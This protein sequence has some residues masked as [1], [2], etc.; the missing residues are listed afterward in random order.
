MK[1]KTKSV[2]KD[3]FGKL[4]IFIFCVVFIQL[5]NYFFG[6]DNSIIGVIILTGLFMFMRGN[7]GIDVRQASVSIFLMFIIVAFAPKLSLYNPFVGIAV[8]AISIALILIL[9]SHDLTQGNHV[10]F[11][12]GYIFCQGYD[13]NGGAYG[14]R[15]LSLV[16][17]ATIIAVLYYLINHK[18]SYR[19]NVMDLFKELDVHS[20][21][22]QWYIRMTVTLTMAMF[23]GQVLSYP[24]MMWV[25]LTILSLTTP[26]GDEHTNRGMA[27]IPAAIIGTAL[28][29]IL[30]SILIPESIQPIVVMLAGFMAM[31]IQNYFI[32]SIYNSFSSL[33]AAILLFSTKDAIILRI[34]SNIIGTVSSVI[35]YFLFNIIFGHVI[36]FRAND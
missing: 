12:M 23:I 18:K 10:S 34:I 29:Y 19:R 8:N 33:G 35:S 11:M 7:L 14:K 2:I 16:I 36:C 32:K 6:V 26:F 21:R 20:T 24:R 13:V 30:F 31:F 25:S 5:H 4:P 15:V 1:E 3:I 27:R 9:S 17:G 22:T 28:F